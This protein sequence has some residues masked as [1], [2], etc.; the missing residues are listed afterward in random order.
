MSDLI[1]GTTVV[2]MD[3]PC[4]SVKEIVQRA[5]DSRS[6]RRYQCIRVVRL[7][8]IVEMRRDL[9]PAE[10]FTAGEFVIPGGVV[11]ERTGRIEL[12]HRVG[13]LVDIADLLRSPFYERPDPPKGIDLIQG[14]RDLPDK[15]RRRRRAVSQFGP[16]YKIERNGR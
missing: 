1:L 16:G 2:K 13:E 11:D 12:L 6:V 15:R 9:G 14:Y 10:Q 3:E 4:F 5:P 7:D 8:R